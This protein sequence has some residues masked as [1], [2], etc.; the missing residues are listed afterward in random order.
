MSKFSVGDKVMFRF[1]DDMIQEFGRSGSI[2]IGP[3]GQACNIEGR[4]HIC[5]RTAIIESIR[6]SNRKN[7][8]FLKNWSDT[9]GDMVWDFTDWMFCLVEKAKPAPEKK[10]LTVAEVEKLLGY[11]VEVVRG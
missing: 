6:K 8:I 7:M 9:K 3:D 10:K 5:G 1:M 2:I 11:G 4:R